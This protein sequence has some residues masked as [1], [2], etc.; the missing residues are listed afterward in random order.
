MTSLRVVYYSAD[1][2]A[3][4]WIPGLQAALPGAEVSLW[5]PGAPQAD[6]AVVWKPPQQL[7]HEQTQLKALFNTGAG[8]DALMKLD[9]AAGVDVEIKV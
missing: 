1:L 4:R 6:Y 8:V 7:L 3:D 5:A 9:L 2:D